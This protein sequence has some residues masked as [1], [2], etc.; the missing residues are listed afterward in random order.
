[1]IRKLT[2]EFCKEVASECKTLKELRKKD[3][4]VNNKITENKWFELIEH[5]D[6][7][8]QLTYEYCKKVASKY[9]TK[10]DL[11]KADSVVLDKI[12][13]QK[14][15]DLFSHFE[16]GNRVLSYEFC[17][18]VAKEFKHIIDLQDNDESVY[19]KILNNGWD[20]LL[21]HMIPKTN[22]SVRCIYFAEFENK[23]GYVGLTCDFKRRMTEH[24]TDKGSVY[25]Y[26]QEK[27]EIPTFTKLTGYVSEDESQLMEDY[28]E[29]HYIKNGYTLLNKK[30]T[31][32]L[33][34]GYERLTYNVC[35]EILKDYTYKFD[36]RKDG[37]DSVLK[38]VYQKKWF[39]LSDHLQDRPYPNRKGGDNQAARKVMNIN[40]KEVYGCASEV[41][42]ILGITPNNFRRKLRGERKNTT[43]YVY[44]D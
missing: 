25:E 38:K 29:K 42:Q 7:N 5:L 35:K 37:Y 33:G 14:W 21:S 22:L 15:F 20:D 4:S 30:K 13:E 24:L 10:N 32:A 36:V 31:G 28:Y 3:R 17:K 18:E 9:K 16:G 11:F 40:T 6:R 44:C 1:M 26:M 34:G 43:G 8:R 41:A 27:N 2:Y 39:E 12:Y 19:L 23:V